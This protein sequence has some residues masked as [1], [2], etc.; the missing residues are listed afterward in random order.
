M[1]CTSITSLTNSWATKYLTIFSQLYLLLKMQP[2]PNEK[3]LCATLTWQFDTEKGL[4]TLAL[5]PFRWP[6]EHVTAIFGVVVF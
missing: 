3:S 1:Q 6:V 5:T 2:C 4:L